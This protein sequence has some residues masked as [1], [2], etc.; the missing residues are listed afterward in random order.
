MDPTHRLDR[1]TAGHWLHK[2][3]ALE[4]R[5]WARDKGEPEL[6]KVV[7]EDPHVSEHKAR[8]NRATTQCG[9]NSPQL[10][11]L[12]LY[13][14]ALDVRRPV[15]STLREAIPWET[16]KRVRLEPAMSVVRSDRGRLITG[17]PLKAVDTRVGR[18]PEIPTVDE[19]LDSRSD[20]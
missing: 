7:G 10:V 19:W 13:P 17:N 2:A 18:R 3:R 5:L 4:E 14:F 15:R 20:R 1:R 11:R 9:P 16:L 6:R 8:R 12:I